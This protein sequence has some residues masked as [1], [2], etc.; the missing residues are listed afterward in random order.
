MIQKFAILNQKF[1]FKYKK[2]GKDNQ[3][4]DFIPYENNDPKKVEPGDNSDSSL[5]SKLNEKK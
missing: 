1:V 5:H 2:R 3:I 4:V